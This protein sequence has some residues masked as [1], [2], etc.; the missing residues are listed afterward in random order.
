MADNNGLRIPL[1]P[2]RGAERD[3]GLFAFGVPFPVSLIIK[4]RSLDSTPSRSP[5]SQRKGIP[6][7]S[8]RACPA[9]TV[10]R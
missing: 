4:S 6:G 2:V 5:P 3:D 1:A 9:T 7:V 8:S 10:Y